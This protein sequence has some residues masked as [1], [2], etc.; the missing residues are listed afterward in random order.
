MEER[1]FFLGFFV[2][3]GIIT[4]NLAGESE[5]K[6][7]LE[8]GQ[9][10]LNK[11]LQRK[12]N[13]NVA[14]NVI[15]FIGDGLGIPTITASRIYKGQLAGKPGEEEV[16]NFERFPNVA[17]MKT[18]NVD[19]QVT[20]SAGAATA[21]FSGVKSN[22]GAI[23]VDSS[24]NDLTCGKMTE[25][26]KLQNIRSW[27]EEKGKSV[28]VVTTTRLTHATPAAFYAHSPS[29]YWE[30]D[31]EVPESERNCKDI[32]KQLI[33][34]TN[35]KVVLGGGRGRFL[36]IND[37]DPEV[38]TPGK[39]KDENLIEA[40]KKLMQEKGLNAKYVWNSEGFNDVVPEETDR[41][42]GM[43]SYDHMRYDFEREQDESGEPSI[44]EM[45][46]MAINILKN[47][48]DKGFFLLVEG[49]RIDHAHHES[50][51]KKAFQD[52]VA[53][54][55]AVK[56][57]LQKTSEEDTLIVVTADHSHVMT[58]GGYP[59]RGNPIMG[60]QDNDV[61]PALDGLPY[62]TIQYSNSR[63]E[64]RVNLTGVDTDDWE[65]IP[66]GVFAVD[67][68][69]HGGED[70]AVYA[71]GPMAHLFEGVQEQNY[72]AHVMAYASCVGPNQAHCDSAG[73][74]LVTSNLIFLCV[75][76]GILVK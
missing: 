16:F 35:L 5:Q 57:A 38:N 37:T 43:F 2:F 75:L 45:T 59:G 4:L 60:V 27:S 72:I 39:R 18:Y 20:D 36:S 74:K 51:P 17:L 66:T 24:V 55:N 19:H 10:A 50:T 22:Y 48:N 42:L 13:N 68:E 63:R 32:A 33:Y 23:G 49:G 34:D 61:E 56:L 3:I 26:S 62:T 58:I 21:I 29:R 47:N 44:G 6:E 8:M 71:Q 54:E 11:A 1:S 65:F 28:G 30:V 14:K 64:G 76:L 9:N 70:V 53:F 67:D 31:G 46:E 69:T 52:T 12:D 41:L 40:W 25:K 73:V 7:W 15:L